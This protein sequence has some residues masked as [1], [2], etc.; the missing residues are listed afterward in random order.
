MVERVLYISCSPRGE[1]SVSTGVAE[2]FLGT[3][4]ESRDVEVDRLD[5][6]RCSLPEVDGELLAA[7][8]AGIKGEALSA[9]QATAW[10]QIKKLVER[11]HRADTLLFSVPLWNYGIPYK[12][13]HL[14]DAISHK[15]FLFAFDERGLTGLLGGRRAVAIYARGLDYGPG[16]QTPDHSFGLERPYLNA[17]FHFVG[18]DRVHSLVIEQTLGPSGK[19]VRADAERRA[20]SLAQHVANDPGELLNVV[21]PE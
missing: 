19:A 16:S 1:Q 15:G 10:D 3:L 21:R 2:A 4:A 11:F 6:W 20:R 9:G 13:K 8:Y 12:L 17:W 7:K 5:L 14:I 18:I